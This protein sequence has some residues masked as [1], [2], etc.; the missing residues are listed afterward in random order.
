MKAIFAAFFSND[1][2]ITLKIKNGVKG[3]M[4]AFG[5]KYNDRRTQAPAAC[6]WSLK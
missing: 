5:G 6:I 2:Q 3:R 4:S 1:V